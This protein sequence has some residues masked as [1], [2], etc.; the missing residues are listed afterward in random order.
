[1]PSDSRLS[2]RFGADTTDFKN[3][4]NALNRE[5]KVVESGFRASASAL[6]DWSGSASGLEM[7]IGALNDKIG[8]QQQKVDA[9]RGE[10]ERLVEAHGADSVAAQNAEIA[11]N[12]ATE[13]LNEMQSE[14]GETQSDLENLGESEDETGNQAEEMG[15]QTE[16]AGNKLAGLKAVAEGVA[17][18]LKVAVAAIAALAAAAVGVGVAVAKLVVDSARYSDELVA[19]SDKTGIGVERLQELSYVA[20]Q[21]GVSTETITGSLTKLTKSMGA[22]QTETEKAKES[23]QNVVLGDTASAFEGLGI[24]VQDVDNNLRD[25]KTVYL[26]TIAAL[27]AIS[28][29]TERDA[30]S[31]DIFGKRFNEINSKTMPA[32]IK[33]M[34]KARDQTIEYNSKLS[35]IGDT[36]GP[37]TEAFAKLGVSVVDSSGHLRDSEAVF[38]DAITALGKIPNEAERDALAMQLFG[39]SAMELNP[40]IK[41]GAQEIANLSQEARNMGA[42]VSED[43]VQGLAGFSDTLDGMKAGL[44]GTL[45]TLAGEFLPGFQNFADQAKGYLQQFGQVVRSSGGDFGKMGEGVGSLIGRMVSDLAKQAPQ[46]LQGGLGIIRGLLNA[47]IVSLPQI[48][49]AITALL[50]ALVDFLVE[51][52]PIL[53]GAALQIITTLA[54]A[55][56]LNL[57]MILQAGLEI[58]LAVIQGLTEALPQLIESVTEIIPQITK[59]LIENLPLLVTSAMQLILAIIMGITQALPQL[60]QAVVDLIPVVINTLLAQLPLLITAAAQLILALIVGLAQALP[61]LI[62]Y[63]P[64]LIQTIID[65]L[66]QNVPLFMEAAVLLVGALIIGIAQALPG[67][68]ES[69]LEII[70]IYVATIINNMATILDVGKSIIEGVWQGIKDNAEEFKKNIEGFFKGIVDG[71]KHALGIGSPSKIFAEI[72][73]SMAQGMTAGW[74]EQFDNVRSQIVGAVQGMANGL[75]G[76]DL[77]FSVAG[78]GASGAGAGVNILGDIN[79]YASPGMDVNALAQAV[80]DRLG[81]TLSVARSKGLR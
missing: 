24:S 53:V 49:P 70:D 78:T 32:F 60:I 58:V 73:V 14:L 31:L 50:T 69:A 42:V 76:P 52:L 28:D 45:T 77:A 41:A 43:T 34:D 80:I 36:A 68:G 10:Y 2:A 13:M 23:L 6:G 46:L 57:P 39:K 17:A 75:G 67:L 7:R 9:L 29:P 48:L 79:V 54:N 5:M 63:L 65:T 33:N 26:E 81:D 18:G 72:G 4:I 30:A 22:V 71:V 38:N 51:S 59:V 21:V 40:L 16:Q 8:L 19:M 27:K 20:D 47:I 62:D 66:Q 1:M 55:L 12:K 25:S 35:L 37:T 15:T 74:V 3:K 56:I 11:Y 44:R 64:T 61:Q